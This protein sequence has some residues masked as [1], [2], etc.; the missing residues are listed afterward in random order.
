MLLNYII[1]DDFIQSGLQCIYSILFIV[2]YGIVS[3]ETHALALLTQLTTED[4]NKAQQF[5][6]RE[7]EDS[8]QSF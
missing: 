3:L 6:N 1:T 4:I 7:E 5:C 8:K 2:Q